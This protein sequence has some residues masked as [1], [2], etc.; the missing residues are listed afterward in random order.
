MQDFM[1][2][3]GKSAANVAGKA[4]IKAGE[5]VE[6]GKVKGKIA[7]LK[8]DVTSAKKSLGDIC[9][10]MFKDDDEAEKNVKG[11][12]DKITALKAEIETLEAEIENIR[13][14]YKEKRES[15]YDGDTL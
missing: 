14:E 7:S 9:Y 1:S 15:E 5:M 3:L 10:E 13:E 12:C 11:I 8:S 6:I 2:K 4:G